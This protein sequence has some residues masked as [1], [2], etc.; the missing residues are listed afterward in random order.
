[1]VDGLHISDGTKKLL[2]IV[3]SGVGMGVRGDTVEVI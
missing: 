1:M 3:L 2:S